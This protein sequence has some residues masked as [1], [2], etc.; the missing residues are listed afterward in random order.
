MYGSAGVM[1]AKVDTTKHCI[2]RLVIGQSFISTQLRLRG[3][4]L[5]I[6]RSHR[7][8]RATALKSPGMLY[9][10]YYAAML[11]NCAYCHTLGVDKQA[12]SIMESPDSPGWSKMQYSF[13][14]I[15]N[16]AASC[17][18]PYTATRIDCWPLLYTLYKLSLHPSSSLTA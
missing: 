1:L 13:S 11:K 12:V 4:Q 7:I 6:K 16:I 17:L 10:E 18:H 14:S 9:R 5:M 15:S 8:M 3:L 2:R